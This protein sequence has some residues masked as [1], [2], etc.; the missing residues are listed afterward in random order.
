MQIEIT[1]KDSFINMD[2]AITHNG[3]EIII[4]MNYRFTGSVLFDHVGQLVS[5]LNQNWSRRTDDSKNK[6]FKLYRCIRRCW[7]NHVDF[8]T[9]KL[10]DFETLADAVTPYM[11]ELLSQH[12]IDML[13][14]HMDSWYKDVV[15]TDLPDRSDDPMV[16]TY[17][18]YQELQAMMLSM[19][20][21]FPVLEMLRKAVPD[22]PLE[23]KLTRIHVNLMKGGTELYQSRPLYRLY[24]FVEAYVAKNGGGDPN[25]LM[26]A[27]LYK[28]LTHY[29]L[30][31]APHG[32]SIITEIY[33]FLA[34]KTHSSAA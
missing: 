18:E 13:V 24:T 34:V 17:E 23:A 28:R 12:N 15:P 31:S 30:A 29:P 1:H 9:G 4:P 6:M 5:E 14:H 33:K 26:A 11:L 25:T 2:A 16:Y 8:T 27:L 21:I 22:Y 10:T 3:E 32:A 20:S 7:D 19:R